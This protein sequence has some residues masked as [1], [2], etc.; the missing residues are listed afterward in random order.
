M[1]LAARLASKFEKQVQ[2]RGHVLYAHRAIRLVASSLSHISAQVTGTD[3][4]DVSLQYSA[5]RL[6]VSCDCPYF[7][8]RG[9]CKHLW[10][11][12]LEADRRGVLTE[13][14]DA[15]FLKFD[16]SLG[17]DLDPEPLELFHLAPPPQPPLWQGQPSY[18]YR[19]L[20]PQN[21]ALE[22]RPTGPRDF[23]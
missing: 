6:A 3:V 20:L 14:R 1:L 5:G 2:V 11:V 4:Y 8:D 19:A 23:D 22:N 10:A 9:P 13:A 16:D 18:I 15:K 12:V 21:P 17:N 7:E